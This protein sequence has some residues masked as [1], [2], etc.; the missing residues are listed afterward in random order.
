MQ[1]QTI[2]FKN[3]VQAFTKD[4]LNLAIFLSHTIAGYMLHDSNNTITSVVGVF[5]LIMAMMQLLSISFR[6]LNNM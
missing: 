1:L 5:L 6:S 2:N 4:L 3:K